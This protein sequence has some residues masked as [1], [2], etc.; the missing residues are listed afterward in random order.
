MENQCQAALKLTKT[1]F[2]PSPLSR[3]KA[4]SAPFLSSSSLLEL[5]LV[6]QGALIHEGAFQKQF[7]CSR[8][9]VF[10]LNCN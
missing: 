1:L 2:V 4:T 3:F 6:L 8:W 7:V 9:L 10:F 5:S